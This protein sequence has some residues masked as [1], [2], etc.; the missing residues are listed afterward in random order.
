VGEFTGIIDL[1]GALMRLFGL[2]ENA[3]MPAIALLVVFFIIA[4][5]F[6]LL[7]QSR[8]VRTGPVGMVGEIGKAATD[9]APEGKVYVHSEYWN[10]VAS[11]PIRAGEAIR[12][13][14]VEG[15]L[16]RVEHAK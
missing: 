8:R 13:V 16:L 1:L 11:N 15:M 2:E 4:V 14:A 7:A 10:A 6:G 9:I 12:I 5:P 3:L